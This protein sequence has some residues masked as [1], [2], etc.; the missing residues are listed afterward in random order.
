ML[1]LLLLACSKASSFVTIPPDAEKVLLL[2]VTA[3]HEGEQPLG[4]AA[5]L[6]GGSRAVRETTPAPGVCQR[7]SAAQEGEAFA[8]TVVVR[9]GSALNLPWIAAAGR[10]GAVGPLKGIDP[11]WSVGDLKWVA[12]GKS[13]EMDGIIRFGAEP[14]V[15]EV[16][17]LS[18]GGVRLRWNS[19][20]SGQLS[21][22]SMGLVCGVTRDGT[23]L[24]WW[25]VPA[26]GGEVVLRSVRSEW[27]MDGDTMVVGRAVIETV[28]PLDRKV[29]EASDQVVPDR[30][31]VKRMPM[32]RKKASMG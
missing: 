28:V 1:P 17:R 31:P 18:D 2:T 20:D 21:V 24:P 14:R 5:Q 22:Q 13:H 3:R 19:P 12:E 32:T 11:A 10:Y 23:E 6:W 8:D 27:R 16:L 25:A 7:P 9:V 30:P 26:L 15:T 4:L 29:E